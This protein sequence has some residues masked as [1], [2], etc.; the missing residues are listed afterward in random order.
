MEWKIRIEPLSQGSCS[1]IGRRTHDRIW[2]RFFEDG[3]KFRWRCL[4][5]GCLELVQ[6]GREPGSGRVTEFPGCRGTMDEGEA[7]GFGEVLGVL[8]SPGC[9]YDMGEHTRD[10]SKLLSVSQGQLRHR[11]PQRPK[12]WHESTPPSL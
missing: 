3:E 6:E 12:Q 1:C 5:V 11:S 9:P 2:E 8:I 10:H 4:G 7:V